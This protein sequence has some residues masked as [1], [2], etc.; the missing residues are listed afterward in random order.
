MKRCW[1]SNNN[2]IKIDT[3]Y[4][5]YRYLKKFICRLNGCHNVTQWAKIRKKIHFA[6]HCTVCLKGWN[7]CFFEK[8][9]SG[10]SSKETWSDF[11]LW[12]GDLKSPGNKNSW[13]CIFGSFSQ[14]KNWFLA[15]FEIAKNGIWLTK[16]FMKW[17]YLIGLEFFFLAHC[18]DRI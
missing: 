16:L 7:Q 18:S 4:V 12:G 1:R 15:V 13:N 5:H 10:V 17:I 11:R 3:E 2:S 6:G 8:L 9:S 14:F